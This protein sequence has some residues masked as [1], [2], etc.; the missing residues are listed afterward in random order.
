MSPS[1]RTSCCR[2]GGTLELELQN[3]HWVFGFGPDV[4]VPIASRTKLFSLVNI[5][6][7][8]E[9]GARTKTEG[10]SLVVTATFPVPSVKIQ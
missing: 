3:K 10:D 7:F 6:Y 2:G 4:T 5:R 9:S 8:W 1:A